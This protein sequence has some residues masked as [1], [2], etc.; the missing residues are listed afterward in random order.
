MLPHLYSHVLWYVVQFCYGRRWL[1]AEY[2]VLLVK[3][4]TLI[5]YSYYHW[6]LMFLLLVSVTFYRCIEKR[7]SKP[8][9]ATI[10][11]FLLKAW[12]SHVEILLLASVCKLCWINVL[13]G[14][15]MWDF[16]GD[17]SCP[18]LLHFITLLFIIGQR[19]IQQLQLKCHLKPEHRHLVKEKCL[20]HLFIIIWL[21]HIIYFV[22]LKPRNKILFQTSVGCLKLLKENCIQFW[23]S[24]SANYQNLESQI[25]W[26]Q[27]T[28]NY[29]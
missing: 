8:F 20:P 22:H 25:L 2:L 15:R 21:P 4:N 23:D 6:T 3:R 7:H 10:L 27:N 16:S 19:T 28:N 18:R 1:A 14:F 26:L 13:I 12:W 9:F 5:L 11:D 24:R 29:S 17:I